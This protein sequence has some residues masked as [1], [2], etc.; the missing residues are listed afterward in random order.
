MEDRFNGKKIVI[1]GHSM[2]TSNGG[3]QGVG[4]PEP[5]TYGGLLRDLNGCTIY[6]NAISGSRVSAP[7]SF[8]TRMTNPDR[9]NTLDSV[10]VPD[11][12]IVDAMINDFLQNVQ[13]GLPTD[14]EIS[15]F[16]GAMDYLLKNMVTR[17]SNT[18]IYLKLACHTSYQIATSPEKNSSGV[19][20]TDF[21]KVAKEVCL[22]YGVTIIDSFQNSG[23]THANTSTYTIDG[24]HHNELGARAE[25]ET[26]R[27]VLNATLTNVVAPSV[28]VIEEPPVSSVVFDIKSNNISNITYSE[29]T[30][31]L[32]AQ[33]NSVNYEFAL[34][35]DCNSVVV[36]MPANNPVA[37]PAFVIGNDSQEN[38]IVLYFDGS[39]S[40]KSF[41][42]SGVVNEITQIT[43]LD[44][45]K[46]FAPKGTPVTI[47]H[48]TDNVTIS[49]G[50]Y[51]RN[52]PY[53]SI[54]ELTVKSI[55][56]LFTGAGVSNYTFDKIS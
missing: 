41:K 26:I 14:T 19:Y 9:W 5:K 35:N 32:T 42:K 34:T 52:I 18:R 45:D 12:I 50:S 20:L 4:I 55:G 29:T 11:I 54:P 31:A 8:P 47:T 33:T 51:T 53:T 6:R 56:C 15:T 25:Y 10:I 44:T 37:L 43:T 1:F 22:R 17:Y 36:T 2:A 48:G 46:P 3:A 49:Y 30:N 39:G 28:I 21:I 13:I 24:I 7:S 16:Y 27:N 38:A 40:I 23:M